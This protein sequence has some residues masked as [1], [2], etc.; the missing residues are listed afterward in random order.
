MLQLQKF[1]VKSKLEF[2]EISAQLHDQQEQQYVT[3]QANNKLSKKD[4]RLHKTEIQKLNQKLQSKIAKI[5]KLEL[6][7]LN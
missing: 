6:K 7:T 4:L 1:E 3:E 5:D 2:N